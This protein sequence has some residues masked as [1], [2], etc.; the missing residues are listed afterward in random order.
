MLRIHHLGRSQSERI[1]WLCEELA[2]PYELA[3]YARDP[4]TRMAPPELK[5]VHPLGTAPVVE[6]DGLMLAESGAI[7][8]YLLDRFGEGRL[9]HG[10]GHSGYAA[11]LYWFHFANGTLQPAMLRALT[12]G[13][14]GLAPEHPVPAAVQARLHGILAH[15]DARLAHSDHLAGEDFTAADVMSVF[16]LSTMRLFLPVDLG[17]YPG[18]RAYLA[19]IGARPGYR[20][21]MRK[22]DPDL[23]PLLE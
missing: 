20:R 3:R 7:V 23:V 8:D 5:A 12:V 22:G 19:R 6:V 1:V 16:P 9:R 14:C 21:A 13:R 18:I 17:P 10:P 2:I 15:V 4:V 11:Y